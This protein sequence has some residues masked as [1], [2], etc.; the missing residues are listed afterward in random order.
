MKKIILYAKGKDRPGIISNITNEINILNGNIETSKMIKLESSF[1]IL[2]LIQI[3]EKNIISLKEKL[4]RIPNLS[5]EFNNIEKSNS[6]LEKMFF[7]RLKGADNE[8]IIHIF[9]NYFY[10]NNINI[11]DL[12]S[13]ISNAPVTGQ[14]L[15]FLK[16]R[17]LVPSSLN[18]S[19][20]ENDLIDLS[21][22]H[23][24]AIKFKKFDISKDY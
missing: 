9:T 10:N 11:L 4:N 15:F 14:T 7:F 6:K 21:N 2:M 12:E 13:E 22:K 1:N 17:L 23:N 5:I 19:D 8:G 3:K 20:V 18:Y 16:T 24:V